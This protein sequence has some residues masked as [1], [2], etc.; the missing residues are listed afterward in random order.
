MFNLFS[1]RSSA[2]SPVVESRKSLPLTI[3][4]PHEIEPKVDTNY[5][6]KFDPFAYLSQSMTP[7]SSPTITSS[8]SSKSNKSPDFTSRSS[9]ATR[10]SD[11]LIVKV[12]SNDTADDSGFFNSSISTKNKSPNKPKV[13]AYY[14]R[15]GKVSHTFTD[16]LS[17]IKDPELIIETRPIP[18]LPKDQFYFPPENKAL[19][20]FH[21][22]QQHE[23]QQQRPGSAKERPKSGKLQSQ[24]QSIKTRQRS[25]SAA[26]ER[27]K[28]DIS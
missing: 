1:Q 12:D 23:L 18:T 16:T 28:I 15:S 6:S 19:T 13:I 5:F 27:K 7:K 8:K 2:V 3:E 4:N 26:V 17:K 20:A 21:L 25:Q 24:S 14:P 9:K 10:S 11:F 22:Q